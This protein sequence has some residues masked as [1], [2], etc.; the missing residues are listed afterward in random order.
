MEYFLAR[1]QW[2]TSALGPRRVAFK[3]SL[4]RGVASGKKPALS[5]FQLPNLQ[6]MQKEAAI[7][8]SRMVMG[9]EETC[10]GKVL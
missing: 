6:D 9:S 4:T 3:F 8:A 5:E 7:W 1:K 2:G 10:R